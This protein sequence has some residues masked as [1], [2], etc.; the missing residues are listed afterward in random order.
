MIK[1]V[2]LLGNK[3]A[4]YKKSRHNSGWLFGEI[5]DYQLKE[6]PWNNKFHG[7]WTKIMIENKS[8][9]FLKPQTF[10]NNSG[11]SVSEMASYF[12]INVDEILV[13]HDDLELPFLKARIQQGGP[14]AG[15]NGLRSIVQHLKSDNFFRL[16]LGIGR[17]KHQDVASYVLSRFSKEE[18]SLL[19]VF[20][21][22]VSNS[23]RAFLTKESSLTNLP[24]IVELGL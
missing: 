4:S 2:V 1:L 18:E 8:I 23:L 7:L 9:L 6:D 15:H 21:Q 13:V 14:L 10:M 22:Q 11:Q 12:S 19:E 24:I 17:P 5:F 3:G 16:R 20:Y